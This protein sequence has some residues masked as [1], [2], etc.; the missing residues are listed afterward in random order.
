MTSEEQILLLMNE[1]LINPR[2]FKEEDIFSDFIASDGID[3]SL[4]ELISEISEMKEEYPTVNKT[5]VGGYQSPNFDKECPYK[6]FNELRSA[7]I[8]CAQ[9]YMISR[10]NTLVSSTKYDWWCNINHYGHFNQI[11]HHKKTDL[12]GLF[13]IKTPSN[14]G[15]LRLIR[16]DGSSYTNLYKN[17]E[18]RLIPEE[19]RC[20]LFPGHL[21][22][23]VE[24][25]GSD[26]ERISVSFNM[27]M[28]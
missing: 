19:G 10:Y 1:S 4:D 13:Y 22:H 16:N 21:W 9:Q 24:P 7:C 20:Y 3:I 18:Y 6:K 15:T 26:E 14:S 5:N 23:M 2:N 27:Y 17:T 8:S 12:I 11:H 28:N 25:H